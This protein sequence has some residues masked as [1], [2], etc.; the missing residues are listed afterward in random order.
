MNA[1]FTI[2]SVLALGLFG[3]MIH[4]TAAE[5]LPGTEARFGGDIT[6]ADNPSFRRHV[7]PLVSK[8]GCS[9]RECHGSL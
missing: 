2:G 8:L 7:V 1:R 9:D 6:N 3:Q 5:D 4:Q